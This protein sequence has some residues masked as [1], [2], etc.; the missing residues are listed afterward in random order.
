M[1]YKNKTNLYSTDDSKTFYNF[2]TKVFVSGKNEI[3]SLNSQFK[4]STKL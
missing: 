2:R 1:K 3:L 4:F